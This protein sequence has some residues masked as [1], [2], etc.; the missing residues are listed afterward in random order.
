M[1]RE[2]LHVEVKH[3]DA[4]LRSP[5]SRG[6]RLTELDDDATVVHWCS[7]PSPGER[8]VVSVADCVRQVFECVGVEAGFATLESALHLNKLDVVEFY[9]LLPCLPRRFRAIAKSASHLSDSGSESCLK[10]ILLGLGVPYRQQVLLAERWPVDFLVGE[11]LAIEA[12]SRAYHSDPYRDRK[13]DAE[14]SAASVRVLRFMYSQIRY[15]RKSVER[16]ILAA[17]ARGDAHSA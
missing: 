13:K 12:D 15:E 7:T 1:E 8:Y 6:T 14:L 11:H 2:G 4:R 17:I 16:S 3:S 9:Q 5:D 10:L